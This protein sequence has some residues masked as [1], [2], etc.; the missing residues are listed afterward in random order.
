[1]RRFY[2]DTAQ[3]TNLVIMQALKSLVGA[4][5]IVFGA[6]YPY[7]TIADHVEA[8]RKCGFSADELRGIDR[9]NGLRLLRH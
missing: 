2:Y 9:D 5:Q 7:S 4:S 6:D 3:S 1:L 8:L